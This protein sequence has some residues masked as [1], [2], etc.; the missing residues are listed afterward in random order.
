VQSHHAAAMLS[1][2]R[3]HHRYWK[4]INSFGYRD[5]EHDKS[6]FKGEKVIFVVGDSF[7]AG[8]GI[9]NHEDRFSNILQKKLDSNWLVVNIARVNWNTQDEYNAII[10]Y[11]YKPDMIILAYLVNDI[12]NAVLSSGFS[13]P[14]FIERPKGLFG[15][16]VE[17]SYFINYVHWKLFFCKN[18]RNLLFD[19]VRHYQ[20]YYHHEEVWNMHKEEL[21]HII[22]HVS[23]NDIKFIPVVFPFLFASEN[24]NVVLTSKVM[25]FFK[26]NGFYTVN[27]LDKIKKWWDKRLIVN[28]SD[29]HPNEFLHY[30]IA[31]ILFDIVEQQEL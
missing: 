9:K 29:S 14:S 30:K 25:D 12:D 21:M 19:V 27:I 1:S 8:A 16:L 15:K 28:S 4:P 24:D 17:S 31:E 18:G 6:D 10:A 13:E 11:P 22:N 3:W 2:Q 5:I 23:D 26:S 7:V 20:K